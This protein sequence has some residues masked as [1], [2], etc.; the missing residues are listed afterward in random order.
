ME[1][2]ILRIKDL[3]NSKGL[4]GIESTSELF[5]LV[6]I[7][8]KKEYLVKFIRDDYLHMKLIKLYKAHTNTNARIIFVNV[9]DQE[10]GPLKGDFYTFI[11]AKKLL[12]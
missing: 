7:G 11:G 5:D 8:Q 9:S 6:L 10:M 2:I 3:F 12:L 1:D 4:K